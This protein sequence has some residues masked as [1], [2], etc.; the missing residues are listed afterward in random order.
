MMVEY[1]NCVI[2]MVMIRTKICPGSENCLSTS[3]TG[4]E[5]VI[6]ATFTG[7]AILLLVLVT[8]LYLTN[9]KPLIK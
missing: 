5:G 4:R 7:S 3:A 2:F 1:P 9:G 6:V 8:A